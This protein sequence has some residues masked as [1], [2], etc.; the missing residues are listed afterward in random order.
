[1]HQIEPSST[2]YQ[3]SYPIME[4][5]LNV[6]QLLHLTGRLSHSYFFGG[7]GVAGR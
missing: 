6:F 1:M 4:F 3:R 2:V 5:L 7:G